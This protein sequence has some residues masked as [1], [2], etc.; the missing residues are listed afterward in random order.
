MGARLIVNDHHRVLFV[1]HAQPPIRAKRS[2]DTRLSSVPPNTPNRSGDGSSNL[3]TE[4]M[5]WLRVL[6]IAGLPRSAEA[7]GQEPHRQVS[8]TPQGRNPGSYAAAAL[9]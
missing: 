9:R 6:R 4:Q 2:G 3:D 5:G 8:W 1:R 7:C